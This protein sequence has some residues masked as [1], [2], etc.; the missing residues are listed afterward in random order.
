MSD[1]EQLGS[2]VQQVIPH[3]GNSIQYSWSPG[4]NAVK[5]YLSGSVFLVRFRTDSVGR[6]RVC[7][8]LLVVQHLKGTASTL[9]TRIMRRAGRN[10]FLLSLPSGADQ[11][12]RLLLCH[13]VLGLQSDGCHLQSLLVVRVQRDLSASIIACRCFRGVIRASIHLSVH[14]TIHYIT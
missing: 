2:S 3:R 12:F 8:L 5:L 14:P 6:F 4:V 1:S 11:A 9:M 10:R 7:R 13:G